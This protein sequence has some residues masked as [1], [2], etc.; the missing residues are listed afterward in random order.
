MIEFISKNNKKNL[1]IFVHG[2]TGGKDTWKN[3]THG[4]FFDQLA[5]LP[6]VAENFD[7]ACFEY[8]TK[9]T[10]LFPAANSYIAKIKSILKMSSDKAEKNIGISEISELFRSYIRF[11]LAGY[12][13]IVVIAHSMGGLV[14]KSAILKDIEQGYNNKISLFISLAVPHLG[15][16]LGTYGKLLSN[17]QQIN[18]LAPLSEFCPRLN[19]KW[20]KQS[21]RPPIKYFYGTYDDVVTKQSAIGTDDIEQDIITCNDDHLTICKPAGASCIAMMAV[22]HFLSDFINGT[23]DNNLDIIKLEDDSQF[24][25]E[26]FVL[27]LLL[28]DVHNSTI[29]HSKEHFLNAEYA[30]KLFSSSS[31]QKKL[32]QLYG[33]IR[34]L[35]QDSYDKFANNGHGNSGELVAEIHQKIISEDAGYLKT[36]LPLIHGLHKKGMLHQLAN[37]LND[38]V[39]WSEERSEE[40][41]RKIKAGLDETTQK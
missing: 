11:Q 31:D 15:A 40:A 18:D 25:D 27:K 13:N 41:L 2:F 37:D 8:F 10:N 7:V 33:R 30:R 22:H 39:W 1:V 12:E 26:F 36:A 9:L 23:S 24:D 35:Y 21:N 17:N 5:E 20:V 14:A 19:N 3:L 38:D 29:K 34:T 16:D 32:G 4:F 28:A 6:L